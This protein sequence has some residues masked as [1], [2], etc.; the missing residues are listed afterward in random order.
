MAPG[1]RIF[2]YGAECKVE[3]EKGQIELGFLLLKLG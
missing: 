1:D 2:G 3:V